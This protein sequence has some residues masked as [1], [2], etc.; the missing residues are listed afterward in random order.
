MKKKIFTGLLF[1][2][3]FVADSQILP[4]RIDSLEKVIVQQPDNTAKADN[5]NTLSEYYLRLDKYEIAAAIIDEALNL[6]IRLNYTYGRFNALINKGRRYAFLNELEKVK[7]FYDTA[8]QLLPSL[9]KNHNLPKLNAKLDYLTG[10]KWLWQLHADSGL[11]YF[12][13]AHLVVANYLTEK[14]D[15]N[16]LCNI[17]S[18]LSQVHTQRGE[19]DSA[20]HYIMKALAI[21]QEAIDPLNL[22]D[23]YGIHARVLVAQGLYRESSA[24]S[25][26]AADIARV[27]GLLNDYAFHYSEAGFTHM[28]AGD[29][30]TA[31]KYLAEAIPLLKQH[32][33]KKIYAQGLVKYSMTLQS[34]DMLD[35]AEEAIREAVAMDLSKFHY[36]NFTVLTQM[37]AV[38][39]AKKEYDEEWK[40]IHEAEKLVAKLHMPQC[41]LRINELKVQ[42]YKAKGNYAAALELLEHTSVFRD[43]LNTIDMEQTVAELNTKY[44]AQKKDKEIALLNGEKEIAAVKLSRRNNY[45]IFLAVLI[46][47]SCI[48]AI[49]IY[50]RIRLK[51]K[52]EI[53]ITRLEQ[54]N[55]IESIRNKIS[56]DMHDDIGASLSKISMLAQQ[57][58]LQMQQGNIQNS[59]STFEKITHKTKEVIS[60]LG[61]MVWAINPQY[62]NLQSM[63]GFMRN[64]ISQ[65]F[66]GTGISYTADFPDEG[67]VRVIHPELKRNLFL[68]L[69]EALNNIVKHS[70]ATEVTI[71]FIMTGEKYHFEISDNGQG[72]GHEKDKSFAN[73]LISMKNRMKEIRGF[74][75]LHSNSG[76]GTRI[77]LEG[78]LF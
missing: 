71:R 29:M 57:A 26:K 53:E 9:P 45:I 67:E 24:Y 50:K 56:R 64:Y 23:L 59:Q 25:M 42:Y 31:Y 14:E 27:Y 55:Q 38:L 41:I 39:H 6:S 46:M 7:P 21:R 68:V 52:S 28:I 36:T 15:T 58:K 10:L 37:C 44:E 65:F 11:K 34:L 63:T 49:S 72:L 1:L 22:K 2:L 47:L 13:K 19:D 78:M 51:R 30:Q 32:G 12:T 40:Y 60:G 74:F 66:E 70:K 54:M 69:K 3:P 75:H 76:T 18:A 20:V 61:T 73:G 33:N 17:L 4:H 77:E 48:A 16:L 8:R 35:K 43:S 5:L 62:D